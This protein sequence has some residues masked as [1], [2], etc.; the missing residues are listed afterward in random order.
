M[1]KMLSLAAYKRALTASLGMQHTACGILPGEEMIDVIN[2]IRNACRKL[3]PSGNTPG[4][5]YPKPKNYIF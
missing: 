5:Q 1:A 4:L 2:P 3:F